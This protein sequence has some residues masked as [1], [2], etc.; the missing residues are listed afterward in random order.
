MIDS[1][2]DEIDRQRLKPATIKQYN[3]V[4]QLLREF[5]GSDRLITSISTDHIDSWIRSLTCKANRT[6][7]SRAMVAKSFFDFAVTRDWI[8]RNPVRVPK[9]GKPAGDRNRYIPW[10][11]FEEVI[12]EGPTA[13]YRLG[14]ALA[15]ILGVRVPSE[16]NSM[17]W[18]DWVWDRGLL[19]IRSPKTGDRV[20]PIYRE[21]E[22]YALDAF[23]AAEVGVAEVFPGRCY[24]AKWH[25]RLLASYR[26]AGQVA[27]PKMFNNLRASASHDILMVHGIA[28]EK[29]VLG[30]S[31]QIALQ[32]Y[33][34]WKQ[35]IEMGVLRAPDL[36]RCE[37]KSDAKSPTHSQP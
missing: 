26:H 16:L 30:H 7:H 32:H 20:V 22:P 18:E 3:F 6:I 34:R 29:N 9:I 15:R 13:E 17:V 36:A 19:L 25:Q 2:L 11:E 35:S 10:P 12:A 21:L 4:A 37:V 27:P 33:D 14:F 31:S 23:E 5:F 8:P 24:T 1:R 28:E